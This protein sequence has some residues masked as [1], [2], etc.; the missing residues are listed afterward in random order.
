MLPQVVQGVGGQQPQE[1]GKKLRAAG[2]QAG[3]ESLMRVLQ[4]TELASLYPQ[5]GANTTL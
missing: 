5:A 3:S 1:V 2:W 4:Y